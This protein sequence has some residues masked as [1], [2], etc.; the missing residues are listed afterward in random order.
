MP[1]NRGS[2]EWSDGSSSAGYFFFYGHADEKKM[3]V[4]CVIGRILF[5]MQMNARRL[6]FCSRVLRGRKDL[7]SKKIIGQQFNLQVFRSDD[8]QIG[9]QESVKIGAQF[10]RQIQ[11]KSDANTLR[12]NCG[13]TN[14][15]IESTT[16]DG[17]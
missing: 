3:R 15:R 9:L 16:K 8:V 1:S 6:K 10:W 7:G 14:N 17:R 11:I 2:P 5:D 12:G 4:E 13:Q